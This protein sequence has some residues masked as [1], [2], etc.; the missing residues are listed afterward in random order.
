MRTGANCWRSSDFPFRDRQELDKTQLIWAALSDP[1]VKI[2]MAGVTCALIA[3]SPTRKGLSNVLSLPSQKRSLQSVN[4]LLSRWLPSSSSPS[5]MKRRRHQRVLLSISSLMRT[6]LLRQM[7]RSGEVSS[8][9]GASGP[10]VLHRVKGPEAKDRCQ[11]TAGEPRK[12]KAARFWSADS[13][14][15]IRNTNKAFAQSPVPLGRG[16]QSMPTASH[17]RRW[18]RP[19]R[20]GENGRVQSLQC[21]GS[22]KVRTQRHV[23]GCF[24]HRTVGGS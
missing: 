3:G 17:E 12:Q 19:L 22:V 2:C 10:S 18:A 16:V 4:V 15:G 20:L 5:L 21:D 6:G 8:A 9:P 13:C 24:P 23:V 14:H 7:P 1:N 11:V